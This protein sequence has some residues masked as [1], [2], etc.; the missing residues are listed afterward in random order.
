MDREKELK[1]LLNMKG[2][3]A[4]IPFLINAIKEGTPAELAKDLG[5]KF[6]RDE[7]AALK[8]EFLDGL[9]TLQPI[10]LKIMD[11]IDKLKAGKAAAPRN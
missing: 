7:D 3:E 6:G 8:I 9:Q 5:S 1:R 11:R 4:V 2:L 10:A